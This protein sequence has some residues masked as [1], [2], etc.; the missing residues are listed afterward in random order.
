MCDLVAC[1]RC[2]K[3]V[4]VDTACMEAPLTLCRSCRE[5]YYDH[6]SLCGC[7]AE[8]ELLHYPSTRDKG[9]C[10]ECY[11]RHVHNRKSTI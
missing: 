1:D 10:D 11:A 5:R 8:R 3:L 2:R 6:C 7:F 4:R 9:Y